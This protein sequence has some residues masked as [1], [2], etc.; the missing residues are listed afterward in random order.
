MQLLALSVALFISALVQVSSG[1]G[2]ALL[3]MPLVI[4][5]VGID[6]A[7][8]LVAVTG[9]LVSAT[10]TLRLRRHINWPE[11]LRM[12]MAALVGIPLGFWLSAHIP[13]G[14]VRTILGCVIMAYAAYTLLQPHGLPVPRP[15]WAFSAGLFAGML[16]AAY[17]IPG[18]PLVVYGTVRQWSR[19]AFRSTLQ[20]FF[21]VNGILVVSGHIILGHFDRTT[22]LLVLL[23]LPALVAGNLAGMALDRYTD[24]SRFQQIIK[25]LILLTGLALVV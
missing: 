21:V 23:A 13:A 19:E 11:L 22:T 9:L 12:G 8:P 17:N 16:G 4:L 18:P 24:A 14:I 15:R 5:L 2:F 10:S 3:A 7:A 25:G 6:R 20:T 1:F